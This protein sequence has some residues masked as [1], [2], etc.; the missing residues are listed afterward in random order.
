MQFLFGIELS[1]L[2]YNIHAL[3]PIF[4]GD[5]PNKRIKHILN[6]SRSFDLILF[7]ENW[8]F[9]DKEIERGLTH[10]N[11]VTLKRSKFRWI[12]IQNGAFR[13]K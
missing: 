12:C 13:S 11:I 3:S 6:G 2:T 9:S 8:I 10:H 5:K 4:A 7:Q 1:I